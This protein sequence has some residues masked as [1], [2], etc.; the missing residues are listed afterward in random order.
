MQVK[1]AAL[2]LL[3]NNLLFESNIQICLGGSISLCSVVLKDPSDAG[4]VH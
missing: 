4:P 2:F 3:L 1:N